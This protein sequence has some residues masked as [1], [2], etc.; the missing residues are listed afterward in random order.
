[1][2]RRGTKDTPAVTLFYAL[3][4]TFIGPSVMLRSPIRNIVDRT[5]V[6]C[7]TTLMAKKLSPKDVEKLRRRA[8]ARAKR[9]HVLEDDAEE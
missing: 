9:E 3:T 6:C 4:C 5:G 7:Y 2:L 8:E 1:M